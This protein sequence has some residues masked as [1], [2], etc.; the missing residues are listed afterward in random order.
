MEYPK[1]GPK[2]LLWTSTWVSRSSPWFPF[3]KEQFPRPKSE[4]VFGT[5][6]SRVLW[7]KAQRGSGIGLGSAPNLVSLP[8]C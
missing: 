1:L 4:S 2:D 8:P 6:R 3:I 5:G 7:C